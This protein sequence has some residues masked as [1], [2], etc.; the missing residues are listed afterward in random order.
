MAPQLEPILPPM[1]CIFSRH[2]V[3]TDHEPDQRSGQ[4]FQNAP[5][6][7][8]QEAM[9]QPQ[10][11]EITFRDLQEGQIQVL[12][13]KRQA[14]MSPILSTRELGREVEVTRQQRRTRALDQ[15]PRSPHQPQYCTNCAHCINTRRF[16]ITP[17][18][19]PYT[20]DD[21][22]SER[23]I[24]REYR[25]RHSGKAI[26]AADVIYRRAE[27]RRALRDEI[28]SDV[29]GESKEEMPDVIEGGFSRRGGTGG[30][31]EMTREERKRVKKWIEGCRW[32]GCAGFGDGEWETTESEG[33]TQ[34]DASIPVVYVE[35]ERERRR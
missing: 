10:Y 12:R 19:C 22:R 16:N 3:N 11:R 34:C 2:D 26:E 18:R 24:E 13:P 17:P 28:R 23:Q 5:P 1:G 31:R 27:V 32:A 25:R 15:R 20:G 21:I 14:S 29:H 7:H 8:F 30:V 6:P 4:G 33:S 35:I 9:Q